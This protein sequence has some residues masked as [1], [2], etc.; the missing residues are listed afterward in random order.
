M[1][2]VEHFLK[3]FSIIPAIT[4]DQREQSYFVRY[5]VYCRE[6]GFEKFKQGDPERETDEYDAQSQ[7]CL[8]IHKPSQRTIGCARLILADT[9]Y[10]ETPLPFERYCGSAIDKN[11]FD[12]DEFLPGQIAEFSRIAVIEEFRRREKNAHNTTQVFAKPR[13]DRRV[14]NFPVI[15][16]CLFLAS[17]SMLMNSEA[18]WGFAMMEPK[19][20]RLL[21]R[22]GVIFEPV[23]EPFNYHGWRS[24]YIIHRSEIGRHFKHGVGELYFEVNRGLTAS[25]K[26]NLNSHLVRNQ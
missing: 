17:L 25:S 26:S 13:N 8:L 4:T 16:V 14:S 12:P 6:F 23:G 5:Q 3:F 18:E 22:Y 1:T 24:P 11:F 2:P 20:E 15:P 9:Q 10:P 19:L 7:H 21:R